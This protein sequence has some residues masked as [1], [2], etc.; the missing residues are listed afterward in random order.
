M[1]NKNREATIKF[2]AD[3]SEY[4]SELKQAAQDMR[5]F[6]AETALA[7]EQLKTNASDTE[8][9]QRKLSSLAGQLDANKRKQEALTGKIEAATRAYGEDSTEVASLKTALTRAKT[10]QEKL[11]RASKNAADAM[12]EAAREADGLSNKLDGLEADSGSAAS[13][14][15]GLATS[16]LGSKIG[17]LAGQMGELV[18]S[19]REY[20]ED[21]V[22]LDTAFQ[23]AGYSADVAKSAY[24]DIF[25]FTGE[26]DRSVEAA[27]RLAQMCDS[28]EDLTEWTNILTG[29]WGTY[30]DSLPIEGL[31]EAANETVKVGTVTGVLADALNWAGVSEDDM[32]AKLAECSTEQERNQ[33]IQSTLSGLYSDAADIYRDNAGSIMEA[34]QADADLADA[35]ATLAEKMEPVYTLWTEIQAAMLGF[36]SSVPTPIIVA[37]VAVL[38]IAAAALTAMGI[39][40]GIAAASTQIMTT[41]Q[42]ALNLVMSANPITIVVLAIIALIAILVTLYNNCEEFR[43]FVDGM[44]AGIQSVIQGIVDWFTGT[45]LPTIQGAIDTVV[46]FFTG[47][48]TNISTVIGGAAEVIGSFGLNPFENFHVAIDAITSFFADTFPGLKEPMDAVK[49]FIDDLFSDPFGTLRDAVSGIIDWVASHFQLPH[50]EFPSIALPHFWVDGGQFPYGIGGQGYMPSFGVN[51]YKRGGIFAANAPQVIGVG[52]ASVPEAVTPIDKL[53]SYIDVAVTKAVGADG[54]DRVVA[55]IRELAGRPNVVRVGAHDLATT[56]ARAY[57]SVNGARQALS[58]RGGALT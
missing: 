22:K 7:D 38:G 14:L 41:A 27:Q 6:K 48:G 17:D 29:V 40:A 32:N 4:N 25:A 34:R 1:A 35:Q 19:S 51:W 37:L 23:N 55:A 15:E 43:A 16:E 20:R 54:T 5:G 3:T 9:H 47:L 42:A 28:E 12:D 18:E 21:I 26:E 10:E 46:G 53:Q 58:D 8:A 33:L 13:A 36:V 31:A 45:F 56:T 30:G 2:R 44:I 57:D 24:R 50:I 52:D 11:E 39:A 49:N